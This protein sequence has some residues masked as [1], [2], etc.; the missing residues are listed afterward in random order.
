MHN[1]FQRAE[2]IL[3]SVRGK[4]I[5]DHGHLGHHHHQSYLWEI[6]PDQNL[7]MTGQWDEVVMWWCNVI[8]TPVTPVTGYFLYTSY[9]RP[10]SNCPLSSPPTQHT[11]G[12]NTQAGNT[13]CSPGQERGVRAESWGE[14]NRRRGEAA[15]AARKTFLRFILFRAT[16][17]PRWWCCWR[18]SAYSPLH[19]VPPYIAWKL[20]GVLRR[21]SVIKA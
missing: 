11:T 16:E 5:P 21:E 9:Q 19:K 4:E 7:N 13:T 12:T 10:A 6:E 3:V 18:P 2:L 20:L 1:G 17:M 8:I 15:T 14:T